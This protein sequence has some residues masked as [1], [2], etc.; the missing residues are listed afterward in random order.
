MGASPPLRHVAFIMDGNGRWAKARG[1]L[2]TSGHRAGAETVRRVVRHA[3]NLGIPYLTLYAFSTENWSRPRVEVE[4]LM[5]LIERFLRTETPE[6]NANGVRLVAIGDVDRLPGKVRRSLD[7]AIAATRGNER[8]TLALALNYGG[9]DEIVRAARKAAEQLVLDGQGVD[10]LTAESIARCLDAPDMPNPDLVVRTAGEMRLSN[11]LIWQAAYAEL[12]WS[13][14]TW[15][16]FGEADFDAAVAEYDRRVRK[17]GGGNPS[18]SDTARLREYA[19]R[20][21]KL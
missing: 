17:F 16:E 13:A 2:R 11:F 1:K 14:K 10:G 6:L 5:R 4:A 21:L 18:D 20:G 8:L 9:R 3:G 12:Y 19:G 7:G 15:P